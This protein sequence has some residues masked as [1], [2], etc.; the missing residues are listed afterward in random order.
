MHSSYRFQR[1]ELK[2]TVDWA[3]DNSS[4]IMY[5]ANDCK[6][7]LCGT[8]QRVGYLNFT[9]P[10]GNASVITN[11]FAAPATLYVTQ[12][13]NATPAAIFG[14][15]L[16]VD[17]SGN[18]ITTINYANTAKGGITVNASGL[19][20]TVRSLTVGG[21]KMPDDDYAFGS[22]TLRVIN[23]GLKLIFR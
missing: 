9:C 5:F 23:P 10:S 14:G 15:N 16:S 20:V 11:S 17:F 3:F 13:A 19:T 12:T 18:K 2:T 1:G 22:G 21:V 4:Q 7:D 8:S 6:W